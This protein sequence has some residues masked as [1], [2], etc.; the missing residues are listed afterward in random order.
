MTLDVTEIPQGVGSG[1]VW[2]QQG[3]IVTNY[4]VVEAGDRASVTLNDGSTYPA[5]IVGVAPDKDLAVLG[6][7]AGFCCGRCL[8]FLG[9][10]GQWAAIPSRPA[11]VCGVWHHEQHTV[12]RFDDRQQWVAI[13]HHRQSNRDQRDCADIEPF[14]SHDLH[15]GQR[16]QAAIYLLWHFDGNYGHDSIRELQHAG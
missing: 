16:Q 2:D 14:K 15:P 6:R 9:D 12:R 7:P 1:F 11:T 8:R 10:V 13:R 3:H 4:H 5:R